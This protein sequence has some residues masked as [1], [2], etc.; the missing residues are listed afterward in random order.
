MP[1]DTTVIAFRQPEAIDDPLTEV[2]RE[3]ARRMLAQ[4]L[5]AEAAP[6]S[7]CGRT[8][9]AGWP[10]PHRAKSRWSRSCATRIAEPV[11]P[12]TIVRQVFSYVSSSRMLAA[13]MSTPSPLNLLFVAV[14]EHGRVTIGRKINISDSGIQTK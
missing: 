2:A 14:E 9:Y 4:V 3:G 11:A 8:W 10:R 13:A 5:I 12:G 7:P 6:L 1:R